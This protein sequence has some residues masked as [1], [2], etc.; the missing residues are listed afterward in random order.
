MTPEDVA[1]AL[2]KQ[3][4]NG[5]FDPNFQPTLVAKVTFGNLEIRFRIDRYPRGQVSIYL[6][7]ATGFYSPY[8]D[9]NGWKVQL[10]S[11]QE[12]YE[13]TIVNGS[14]NFSRMPKVAYIIELIQP[15]L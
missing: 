14:V 6:D 12:Q 8:M 4:H 13:A 10:R 15:E 5:P 1:I 11:T 9:L 3:F 7:K 2:N